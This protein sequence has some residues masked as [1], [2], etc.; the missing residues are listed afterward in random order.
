MKLTANNDITRLFWAL[1][2]V[3]MAL[4]ILALALSIINMEF[5]KSSLSRNHAAI[6]GVLAEKYPEA[7]K[8]IIEQVLSADDNYASMG[9]S[10]LT[11]YG[12]YSWDNL[13]D[14]NLMESYYRINILLFLTLAFL[15][16]GF[17]TIVL[18]KFQNKQYRQINEIT[19]YTR[20]IL[21]GD[22]SLDIRD[23]SE[24]EI[25]ILKNEVYKITTMLKEQATALEHEKSALANS[26]ADITHQLKTPMTSVLVLT[27]LLYGNPSP[28]IKAEFLDRM[29]SQL[30]RMEWLV[31]SLLKLAKIDA[32]AI[33]MN[34]EEVLVRAIIDKVVASMSIPLDIKMQR[35]LIE[36]ESNSKFTGDFNWTCEALVNILKNC[37]EHTPEGGLI[38]ISFAENPLYTVI[39]LE[40]N[41]VGIEKEDLPHIFNRFY[42]GKNARDDS[43]GIG[44]AM[45]R[46]IIAKQ[47]GDITVESEKSRGSKFTVKFFK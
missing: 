27:D 20:K 37:I 22:Y 1:F 14:M 33:S 38:R 43:V 2:L 19:H 39:T 44:L 5:F 40:D 16:G 47:G 30:K 36:G 17:F 10:A 18:F 45:A 29:K 42:K 11:R 46:A 24:G 8:D 15:S 3:L 23:N 41:G 6:I 25:S 12:I 28:E 35:V 32:G 4:I 9:E 31:T 13:L 26:L 34:K 7:E 21:K